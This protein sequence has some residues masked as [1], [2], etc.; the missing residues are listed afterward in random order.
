MA[1]PEQDLID[2]LID[3]A[4]AGVDPDVDE[5]FYNEWKEANDKI[6]VEGRKEYLRQHEKVWNEYV[7]Y[8]KLLDDAVD[9]GTRH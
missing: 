1:H 4:L 9:N 5:K 6:S 7:T 2:I 3:G 8:S